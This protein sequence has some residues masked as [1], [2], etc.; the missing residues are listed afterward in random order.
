[1]VIGVKYGTEFIRDGAAITS[2]RQKE[3]KQAKIGV[4]ALR[5]QILQWPVNTLALLIGQLLG[6]RLTCIYSSGG[7]ETTRRCLH[8][9]LRDA[10]WS[11]IRWKKSCRNLFHCAD[12]SA[13]FFDFKFILFLKVFIYFVSL[14]SS[15]NLLSHGKV[16]F[17]SLYHQGV[18]LILVYRKCHNCV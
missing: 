4:L 16:S 5:C 6:R 18:F 11:S 13:T 1:M 14:V 3:E 9:S 12:L 17:I 10:K 2:S 8:R 15:H 7:P